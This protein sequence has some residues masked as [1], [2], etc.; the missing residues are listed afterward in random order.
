MLENSIFRKLTKVKDEYIYRVHRIFRKQY[1]DK[2]FVREETIEMLSDQIGMLLMMASMLFFGKVLGIIA[3]LKAAKFEP[4][5]FAIFA[6]IQIVF[7]ILTVW[8]LD[9]YLN[10]RIT[11]ERLDWLDTQFSSSKIEDVLFMTYSILFYMFCMVLF[12][13]GLYLLS[14]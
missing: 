6:I 5:R 4:V 11:I 10:K 12:V 9:K 13:I 3:L 2:E 14:R 7:F 1:S 8:L